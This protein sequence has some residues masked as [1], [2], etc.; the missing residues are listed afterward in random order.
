MSKSRLLFVRLLTLL[1]VA[2]GVTYM[3]WR[4]SSTIAWDAW[5]IAIPLVLAETYS[6]SESVLYGI[7][8]WNSRRRADPPPAPAGR[9]V[10]VFIATYNEPLDIV[11]TTA[12]AAR[13]I[14]YPHQTWILDDGNRPEFAEAARRIGVGYL[15]R[16]PDWDG[17]PRFAKAGNVNNALFHT[18]GEFIAVLD[19]D[20]VPDPHFLDRVLGY[21]D[22]PE[23]AFVQTP[24]QFWNV[25]RSDP[26]G[27]QAELFY[28]PIQQGKDG[29][30]G[31][32]FCGSNAVLRREA[33]MALGLTMFTRT[34]AERVRKALRDGRRRIQVMVDATAAVDM[35]VKV[36]AQRAVLALTDAEARV[37]RGDVLADAT[38]D[39]RSFVN[40]LNRTEHVPAELAETLGNVVER[41]DVARTNQALALDPIN[42]ASV[43]EDMATA[44]HLHALGWSSVYHHEVLVHGLAPEDVRTMLSQRQRW[45]TGTM[46]VFFTDN[47]MLLRGLAFSQRL[48]YLS[49][50]TS[51]LNGFAA[52]VYVIA[53][54]VFLVTGRFPIRCDS[55]AFF[56]YFMPFFLCC[57]ALYLVAGN[58]AK[59]LWR[60]QQ[61]SFAL[62]PTWIKATVAGAAAAF[63]GKTLKFAV[64]QKTKQA[65]GSGIRHVMPQVLA[66]GVLAAAGGYGAVQAVEGHRPGFAT[67]I[68]LLWVLAD[69][70]LLSAMVRAGCYRGPG[71][72]IQSP[73]PATVVAEVEGVISDVRYAGAAGWAAHGGEP[74]AAPVL[75]AVGRPV[76]PPDPSGT[77]L[78][79]AASFDAVAALDLRAQVAV[80]LTG[81]SPIVLIDVS[82]VRTLTPSG[83]AVMLDLLRMVRSHGGDLRIIGASRGCFAMAHEMMSLSG[84][85]RLHDDHAAAANAAQRAS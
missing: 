46:Q 65:S 72:G 14:T 78:R 20:Q 77:Q 22:D 85:T 27:S 53:P 10:D 4:W 75:V 84:I 45:A 55:I 81:A 41:A 37:R 11:L 57:Q 64:T 5:W 39:L 58:G 12:V 32:F 76:P 38:F 25:P 3:Q 13:D 59:G 80:A 67:I 1:V 69:L 29:W 66:M 7:T 50:M 23:V 71:D 36:I 31:A 26:L 61:M 56:V 43:T 33:L 28:G 47:P 70:A 34:A 54:T 82:D 18:S 49:T 44:M 79:A 40:G 60:G 9:S 83:V 6:L 62:F 19:A 48:M 30:G 24:Q 42:T 68:T 15:V 51:Y 74:S 2:F 17:R 63:L 35:N 73:F 8:M 52:I 21:F 16:G